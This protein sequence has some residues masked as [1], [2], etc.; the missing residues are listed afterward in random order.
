[1]T[2]KY[3]QEIPGTGGVRFA[4]KLWE[5]TP[6]PS[7][8]IGSI[9]AGVAIQMPDGEECQL[10]RY[11]TLAEREDACQTLYGFA[12]VVSG[13]A[14]ECLDAR[15]LEDAPSPPAQ[16]VEDVLTAVQVETQAAELHGA[17]HE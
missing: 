14:K 11:L 3:T 13:L 2:E 1:M 5:V 9:Y 10:E 16:E 8:S 4:K 15:L 17:E 7:G 12:R 6:G